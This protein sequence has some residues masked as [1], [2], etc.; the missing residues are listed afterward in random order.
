MVQPHTKYTHFEDGPRQPRTFEDG[1]RQPRTFLMFLGCQ[2]NFVARL[3]FVSVTSRS[4]TSWVRMTSSCTHDVTDDIVDV[5]HI[6]IE[7]LSMPNFEFWKL[8]HN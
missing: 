4:M 6:E 1:P 5:K 7:V 2:R 8:H 3:L